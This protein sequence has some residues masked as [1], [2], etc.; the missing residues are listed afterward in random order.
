MRGLLQHTLRAIV[1]GGSAGSLTP[2]RQ[3][4]AVLPT[5]KGIRTYVTMHLSP[6]SADDW[7]L[8]FSDCRV[9]IQEAEDKQLPPLDSVT[10]APPDY[11]LLMDATGA[12]S[13]SLEEKVNFARPSIDVLFE[14]AAW[15]FGKDVLGIIL[16]GG[17]AD[18]AAG[19][20]HIKRAGGLCWVQS[21]QTA[22]MRSM[23]QA[24]VSAAP[25][26]TQLDIEQMVAILCQWGAA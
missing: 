1:I 9:G 6:E 24:A 19:L 22:F 16:S 8:V 17:G 15:A 3:L 13:L 20:A 21:P 11:H 26:A 2:L 14:S 10:I 18:G 12:V 5:N 7:H 25:E 23:P 4:L